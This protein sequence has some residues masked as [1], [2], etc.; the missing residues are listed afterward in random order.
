HVGLQ[1]PR[2][3]RIRIAGH[4]IVLVLVDIAAHRI[5]LAVDARLLRRRQCPALPEVVRLL[6]V[7]VLLL[8]LELAGFLRRQLGGL[9]AL[10]DAL[11]LVGV[12]LRFDGGALLLRLH[13]GGQHQRQRDG[14]Q[15]AFHDVSSFVGGWFVRD[16]PAT[17]QPPD[18]R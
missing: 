5:L 11:L 18:A 12:A 8:A 2:R 17:T 16:Y 6:A 4:G 14:D 9:Q 15:T 3:R 13:R 7:D 10:F 1:A